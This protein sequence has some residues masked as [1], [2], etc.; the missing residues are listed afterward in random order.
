MN[1]V[2][3]SPFIASHHISISEPSGENRQSNSVRKSNAKN[4]VSTSHIFTD[5]PITCISHVCLARISSG[6]TA[7]SFSDSDNRGSFSLPQLIR[8]TPRPGVLRCLKV[9]LFPRS[10]VLR[11][12]ATRVGLCIVRPPRV[13]KYDYMRKPPSR[14]IVRNKSRV[15]SRSAAPRIKGLRI[16]YLTTK[17]SVH[18][19]LSSECLPKRAVHEVICAPGVQ[20]NASKRAKSLG[21]AGLSFRTG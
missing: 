15:P 7:H 10:N 9:V 17:F 18:Q 11:S 21:R 5:T 16:A 1:R 4:R 12:G 6:C 14:N 3:S 2:S 20:T 13:L 19:R 8:H